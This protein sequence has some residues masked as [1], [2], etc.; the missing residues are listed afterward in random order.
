MADDKMCKNPHKYL[1]NDANGD[2]D[3]NDDEYGDCSEVIILS[4]Y[5]IHQFIISLLVAFWR[6]NLGI[7]T[8]K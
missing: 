7:I 4:Q 8:K 1:L 5:C 3:D 2:D 6:Y